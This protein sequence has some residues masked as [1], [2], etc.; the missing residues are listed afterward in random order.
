MFRAA[1]EASTCIQRE[2][3]ASDSVHSPFFER[4]GMVVYDYYKTHKAKGTRF[5]RAMAGVTQSKWL[6]LNACAI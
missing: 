6:S 4:H 2:P 5:T 3:Y 1:S